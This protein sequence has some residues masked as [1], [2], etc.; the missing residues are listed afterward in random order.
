VFGGSLG[1]GTLNDAALGLYERWRDRADVAVHHVTGPRNHEACAAR[2][3][4]ARRPSDTLRYELVG[5]EDH[6]ERLYARTTLA[7]CR[8]GAITVAEL[9]VAGVPAVLVPLPGAPGDHQARN[10]DALVG[11]GAAVV[12][13]DAECDAARLDAELR[14]LLADP[15]RLEV[16]SA[17]AR[18]LGRPDAAARLADLVEEVAR[19]A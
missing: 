19:G 5:Y 16:M 4:A 3:A 1:A 17:N 11:A 2:L 14:E 13:P 9:A 7:V 6:M 8:A 18:T 15:G 10:A 12:V